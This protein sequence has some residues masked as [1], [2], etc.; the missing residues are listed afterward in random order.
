MPRPCRPRRI[1]CSPRA[2]YFKPQGIP[3]SNLEEVTLEADELEAI[4]LIDLKS[5]YQEEAAKRMDVSRQTI[6]NIL[7]SARKKI[8][9][10]LLNAKAL[11]LKT[12]QLQNRRIL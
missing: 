3:L 10:V 7:S 4:R 5:L 9:D 8:A 6:G 11:Q 2:D 1:R 12:T